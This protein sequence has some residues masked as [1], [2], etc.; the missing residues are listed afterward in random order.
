MIDESRVF[1]AMGLHPDL[2]VLADTDP[3]IAAMLKRTMGYATAQLGLAWGDLGRSL[4]DAVEPLF[5]H[6]R[7]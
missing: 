2:R 3:I 5:R 1:D 7:R 4:L 6:L